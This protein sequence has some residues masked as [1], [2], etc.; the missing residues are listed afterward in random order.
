M[1]TSKSYGGP[2]DTSRLLPS[3]AVP[4]TNVASED[5]IV[6]PSTA[7][8]TTDDETG[9]VDSSDR[10]SEVVSREAA[11]GF[12][13]PVV[14]P[15]VRTIQR[16][17]W[18]SAK[19]NLTSVVRGGSGGGRRDY[20]KAAKAYVRARGGSRAAAKS[21]TSGAAATV[22]LGAFLST[23][24]T[25]GFA[26]AVHDIGLT[27]LVGRAVSEIQAAIIN[28]LA[29]VGATME[30]AAARRA[31]SDTIVEMYEKAEV[32]GNSSQTE[33]PISSSDIA[34]LLLESV[35]GYIYYR[36]SQEV[37]LAI[38][39]GAITAREAHAIEVD[40]REYIRDSIQIDLAGKNILSIDWNGSQ[41]K[42]L[43]DEVY[44]E[45]YSLIEAS[46]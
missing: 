36:W 28:A 3:W 42:L 27:S 45:A 21:S 18:A 46:I 4:A 30:E 14:P 6:E 31:V 1:G 35:T 43:V 17:P 23:A 16:S 44:A 15:S 39:K 5:G 10:N 12:E 24:A 20:Q 32:D 26:K 11:G 38:E 37:G 40:M 7:D 29:P 8:G 19:R 22:R 33:P 9:E 13:E 34:S 2:V 41:G 25:S